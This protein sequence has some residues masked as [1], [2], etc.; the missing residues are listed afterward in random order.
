MDT[1]NS[2]YQSLVWH[3]FEE[4]CQIPRP[5]G[6]EQAIVAYLQQFA[7]KHGF[8][9]KTDAAGNLVI[10]KPGEAP[11]IALQAH[12]DMVCEKQMDSTHNFLE[13]PINTYTEDG[14]V[15]YTHL[16]LPT[17]LLV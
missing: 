1:I 8:L 7:L 10:I 6:H 5:S 16:T 13:D 12:V 14:S 17:I 9:S 3:F 2:Q 11:A 4:I 15:S